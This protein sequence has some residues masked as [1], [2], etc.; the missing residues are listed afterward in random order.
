[1]I[2]PW[3][4]SWSRFVYHHLHHEA[5]DDTSEWTVD[6]DGGPMTGANAALPWI[7][8]ERDRNQFQRTFPEWK[9]DVVEPF[10]PLRYLVSGGL[11][12]RALAPAWSFGL[13]RWFESALAFTAG[14]TAMFARIRLERKPDATQSTSEKP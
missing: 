13:W 14:K 7:V 3:C 4:T 10:M 6:N 1:M 9:I 11:S 2:E 8:F 12:M 5:I